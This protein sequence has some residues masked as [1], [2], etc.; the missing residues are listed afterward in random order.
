[1]VYYM[2]RVQGVG[3]RF[4]ARD[5]ASKRNLVGYVRNEHDG[6]V[7]LVAE[8]RKKDLE[9]LLCDIRASHLGGNIKQ[10][11]VDWLEAKGEFSS[12]VIT[13]T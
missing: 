4:N 5:L 8:G 9:A 6:S 10:A 3:F 1:M 13:C 12:F 11:Q 7:N 2:G